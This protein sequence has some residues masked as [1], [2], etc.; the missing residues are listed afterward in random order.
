MIHTY[1]SVIPSEDDE[2][3]NPEIEFSDHE[4]FITCEV[5]FH[6]IEVVFF[7]RNHRQAIAFKNN[8]LAAYSKFRKALNY[9]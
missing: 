7:L 3:I 5:K 4:T 8:L 6:T 9:E 1:Y 2:D